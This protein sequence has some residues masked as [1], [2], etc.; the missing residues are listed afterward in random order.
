M[1]HKLAF[2]IDYQGTEIFSLEW[3]AGVGARDTLRR[4]LSGEKVEG[5]EVL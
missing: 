1:E 3:Q 5:N 2:R 4:C